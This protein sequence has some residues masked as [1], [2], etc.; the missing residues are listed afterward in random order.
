VDFRFGV[1]V[2]EA[3]LADGGG[4]RLQLS[5]EADLTAD[6][7]AVGIGVTP[8]SAL[9][10]DCGLEVSQGGVVVDEHGRTS[11]PLIFAAGEVTLHYNALHARHD[12]QET[13]AH[14]AAH[15][16]HVGRCVI[17]PEDAYAETGS[18]W[19]DQ[20][21]I[22][23]QVFGAPIGE[24]DVLRGDPQSDKFLVFHISDGL[25]TG[26]SAVNS[27]RELRTAR[28]LIGRPAPANLNALADPSAPLAALT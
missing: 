26:V 25:V 7:I 21:D 20:Y 4:L 24:A 19:S 1:T 8:N 11:D 2:R 17:A 16:L 18:Y 28:K 12:R 14:A 23:L 5:D 15:G 9:A 10:E 6:V 13:W 27:V 3:A 22:N